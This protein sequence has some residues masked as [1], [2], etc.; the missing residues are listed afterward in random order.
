M[1]KQLRPRQ[2]IDRWQM[3][4]LA[5]AGSWRRSD[6]WRTLRSPPRIPSRSRAKG[7]SCSGSAL[8]TEVSREEIQAT[9]VD[10]FFPVVAGTAR[11]AARARTALTQIGLP[12]ASDPAIASTWRASARQADALAKIEELGASSAG[13]RAIRRSSC[14]RQP[15]CSTAA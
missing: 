3:V 2:E 4:A 15:C 11:P 9:L 12:Y 6:C 5:H 7:R 1:A 8:R 10:G 13:T 14:T